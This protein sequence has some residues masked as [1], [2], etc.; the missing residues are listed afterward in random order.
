MAMEGLVAWAI[1]QGLHVGATQVSVHES[2]GRLVGPKGLTDTHTKD[3]NGIGKHYIGASLPWTA[4]SA[5][6]R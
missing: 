5:V 4:H 6:G 3:G 2:I 1:R